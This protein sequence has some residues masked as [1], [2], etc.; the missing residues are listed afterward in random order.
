MKKIEVV[1]AVIYN[2]N[3]FLAMQRGYGEFTGLWEFPGG[4]IETRETQQEALA[5]EIK[6]EL[7][8]EISVEHFI[9]TTEH[10]YPH[11]HLTMHSYFCHII[12]GSIELREHKSALWLKSEELNTINWLPADLEIVTYLKKNIII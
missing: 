10:D 1:A 11:F 2:E 7:G 12:K 9:C 5:R 4:K 6:E 8:I 3:S